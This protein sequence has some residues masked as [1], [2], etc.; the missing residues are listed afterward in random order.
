MATKPSVLLGTLKE[1]LE[2][3]EERYSGYRDDL[4][5]LL[6]EVVVLER[7]HS[8]RRIEIV[9]QIQDRCEVAGQDLWSKTTKKRNES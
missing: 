6:A 8:N 3:V 2:S 5:D 4:Y 1:C 9:K 7:S